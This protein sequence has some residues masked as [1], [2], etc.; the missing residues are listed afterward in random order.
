MERERGDPDTCA[1]YLLKELGCEVM[2]LN[3]DPNGFFPRSIEPTES[4]LGELIKATMTFG[5][6][7]GI[8]HD[9]D[10]DRMMVVDDKGRFVSGDR[11]LVWYSRAIL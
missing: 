1:P 2:A 3:C 8:A 6:D 4:N 10:A 5:A 7:L 11:L 9:E